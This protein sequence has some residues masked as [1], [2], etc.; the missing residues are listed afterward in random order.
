MGQW[1]IQLKACLILT[2]ACQIGPVGTVSISDPCVATEIIPGQ[3]NTVLRSSA[4]QRAWVDLKVE[5]GSA[6]PFSDTIDR[7][8]PE[9][10]NCGPIFYKLLDSMGQTV[11]NGGLLSLNINTDI[12]A[13]EPTL[14]D[15]LGLFQY[16]LHA[17]M[18]DYPNIF[19][20]VPFEVE[21]TAC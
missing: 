14:Y 8:Y 16:Y 10:D 5:M 21:V 19:V 13:A 12:L 20:D 11:L 6:Y 15:R 18:A 4:F 7:K 17:Y 1:D 3:I 9:V 2:G